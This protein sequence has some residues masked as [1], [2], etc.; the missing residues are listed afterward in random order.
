MDT[1]ALIDA[2]RA[3]PVSLEREIP[4]AL[5]V[6]ISDRLRSH[7]VSGEWPPHY[8]LKSE[9]DLAV[10]FKVSRGTLRRALATLIDEGLLTQVQG[11]GTFVTSTVIEPAIAQR[12]SSLSEDFAAQGVIATT[13]VLSVALIQAPLPIT[14]L[15]D[16]RVGQ[17][18]LEL[19]RLR[20]IPSGP[21]AL[22]LNYVRSDLAPGLEKVD[23]STRSLFSVLEDDYDLQIASGRRTFSARGATREVASDL[24][25][26]PG[27]PVQYLE[28]ITY[29]GD[30]RPLEYSDVWIDSS[31]LRITSLLS[32]G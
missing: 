8:R 19:R 24:Q 5:H 4:V 32:R 30:G 21:V 14:N 22:L 31:R 16:M 1:M 9:P 10:D 25:L 26:K 20:S 11:K 15:L 7:I 13:Q 18:V 12:L 27:A 17:E 28:Q 23:F 6:Q 3:A 29:L 2:N